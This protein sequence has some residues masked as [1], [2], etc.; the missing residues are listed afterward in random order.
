MSVSVNPSSIMITSCCF[1]TNSQFD[2]NVSAH[3]STIPERMDPTGDQAAPKLPLQIFPG[4]WQNQD[5]IIQPFV[6]W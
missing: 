2:T 6:W 1:I 3:I 5:F 4:M